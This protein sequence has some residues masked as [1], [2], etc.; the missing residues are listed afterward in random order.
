MENW[1]FSSVTTHLYCTYSFFE[2]ILSECFRFQCIQIQL[3]EN[4]RNRNPIENHI[5]R[6]VWKYRFI[7]HVE[8]W[9]RN[10]HQFST[11]DEYFLFHYLCSTQWPKWLMWLFAFYAP[12]WIFNQTNNKT[13]LFTFSFRMWEWRFVCI[14][15]NALNVCLSKHKTEYLV[16]N[17]QLLRLKSRS[18][19]LRNWLS[20]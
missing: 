14:I 2:K 6:W 10:S 20:I 5:Y 4:H 3:K 15:L 17:V 9:L 11:N 12:K 1:H 7:S 16:K 8:K 19:H 13:D 18:N